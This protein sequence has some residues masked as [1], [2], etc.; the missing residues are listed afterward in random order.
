M[1][2]KMETL[3][4]N[5]TKGNKMFKCINCGKMEVWTDGFDGKYYFYICSSCGYE[6][7][8]KDERID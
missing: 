3:G 4:F 1:I 7:K 8:T 2:L 5:I 6:Q